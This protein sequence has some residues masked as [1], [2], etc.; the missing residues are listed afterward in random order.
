MFFFSSFNN[1]VQVQYV[2]LCVFTYAC[3]WPHMCEGEYVHWCS[4]TQRPEV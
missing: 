4:W 1:G 3:M 2:C